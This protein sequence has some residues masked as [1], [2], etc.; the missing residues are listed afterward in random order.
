MSDGNL[1]SEF[2]RQWADRD[3]PILPKSSLYSDAVLLFAYALHELLVDNHP[4]YQVR[5]EQV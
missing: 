4:F 3:I 1:L 2:R 5:I